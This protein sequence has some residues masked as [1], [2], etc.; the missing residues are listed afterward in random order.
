MI[1]SFSARTER[2]QGTLE[3]ILQYIER[4]LFLK[5]N[6]EK[7]VVDHISKVKFL[8]FTFYR[9]KGQTRVR[10]HPKAI[11]KMKV[12]IK[13]LTARSNGRGNE[14]RADNLRKYITGW[15]N[16]FK[17]ADMKQLPKHTDEWMSG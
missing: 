4:R 11:V 13:E 2:A 7:T 14:Q 9:Y 16:Y 5:V 3:N 6:R 12:R 8:G 10:I 1:W 15:I 17:L